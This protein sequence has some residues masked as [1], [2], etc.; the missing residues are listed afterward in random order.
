MVLCPSE[1]A[2]AEVVELVGE[3]KVIPD[4]EITDH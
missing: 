4:P 2:E 3:P 1:D